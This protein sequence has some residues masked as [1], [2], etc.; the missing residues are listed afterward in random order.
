M[1]LLLLLT[2]A[3]D[4]KLALAHSCVGYVPSGCST[5]MPYEWIFKVKNCGDTSS[6]LRQPTADLYKQPSASS[7]LQPQSV[8]YHPIAAKK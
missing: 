8:I 2:A 3:A 1:G 6:Q 4:C 5:D 7:S